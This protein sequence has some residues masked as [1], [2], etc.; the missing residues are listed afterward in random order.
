MAAGVEEDKGEEGELGG[1]CRSVP[2]NVSHSWPRCSPSLSHED[3]CG[4][5]RLAIVP[6]FLCGG[7]FQFQH[8]VVSYSR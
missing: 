1:G 8:N 4:L 3:D 5:L 7:L 6:E 2:R